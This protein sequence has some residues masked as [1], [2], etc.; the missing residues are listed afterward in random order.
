MIFE[1][2]AHSL[3]IGFLVLLLLP[4]V[5][6]AAISSSACLFLRL[7]GSAPA[8]GMGGC[9]VNRVDEYAPLYN[10][11][12]SGL[13]YMNK[14]FAFILPLRS[15][16]APELA[17][18]M[19]LKTWSTG[20][21]F[22]DDVIDLGF[23]DKLH[24]S[25]SIS[26]SKIQ[27]DY[28]N[29]LR[30]DDVGNPAGSCS[31]RDQ[32]THYTLAGGVQYYVR[33]GLG[34]TRK[35]IKSDLTGVGAGI[36]V[37]EGIAESTALDW[38]VMVELPIREMISL[39][40]PLSESTSRYLNLDITPSI[41]YVKANDGDPMVYV[42]AAGPDPLPEYSKLGLSLYLGAAVNE[43]RIVSLR[44]SYEKT[45]DIIT[46]SADIKQYGLEL[47]LKSIVNLRAGKYHDEE[48]HLE[49]NTYG[50]GL[51]LGRVTRWLASAGT[52]GD[53]NSLMYRL[54]NRLDINLDYALYLG[55]DSSVDKT[56]F[57]GISLSI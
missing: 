11:G 49:Y 42:A 9:A 13:F 2:S 56:N 10:P 32:A 33:I 34:I 21:G 1:R 41:A 44:L 47:N 57:I 30:T 48:G 7:V 36:E 23:D 45:K 25:M 26:Y 39:K 40:L 8:N 15:K 28:G 55:G 35:R 38:G 20:V 43:A 51:D 14:S 46:E 3:I 50:G 6:S 29:I 54:A 27:V 17:D 5:A 4:S 31:P 24:Y 18:D 37:G 19:H 12:A 16:W 52:L 22:S 53:T